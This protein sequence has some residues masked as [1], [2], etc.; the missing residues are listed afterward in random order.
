MERR[1]ERTYGRSNMCF[2]EAAPGGGVRC[3]TGALLLHMLG[4]AVAPTMCFGFG[5][6]LSSSS[7]YYRIAGALRV[8][9]KARLPRRA[10]R[11]FLSGVR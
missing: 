10:R 2:E 6:S 9:T 11:L 5:F 8:H 3:L 4:S 1:P 7:R